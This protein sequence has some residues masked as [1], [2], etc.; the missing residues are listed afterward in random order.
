[1]YVEGICSL[2]LCASLGVLVRVSVAVKR[3]HNHGNSYKGKY[4]IGVA[5]LQFR[6]LVHYHHGRNQGSLQED[7][8]LESELSVLT[9]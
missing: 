9:S 1:M 6:A 7:M 2:V 5:H 4:L 8:V 3:H